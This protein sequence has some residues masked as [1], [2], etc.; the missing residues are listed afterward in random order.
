MRTG[1]PTVSLASVRRRLLTGSAWIFAAKVG[2]LGLGVVLSGLIAR[3]LDEPA[4]FGAYLMTN[5]LVIVGS[6]LAKLGLERALVR[7]VAGSIGTRE[8]GGARDAIRIALGWGAIGAAGV[9]LALWLG[10]GR[11]F[12]GDVLHTPLVASIIPIAAGWLF[13]VAMQSLCV[14][15]FRGLSRFGMASVLDH[16]VI[17]LVTTLVLGGIFVAGRTASLSTVVGL[18]AAVVAVVLVITGALLLRQVREL[19][20]P[21]RVTRSDMFRVARPLLVTNLG[22]YLLGSGVDLWVLGAFEPNR[23]VALYG[24]ASRLVVLV[25]TPLIIFSGVIPP[26]VAELHA[27]GRTAQLERALRAGA[28]LAGLPALGI[29]AIFLLFGPFVLATVYGELYRDAAPILAVLSIGRVLAVWAGSCGVALMMTGHQRAMM[30]ITLVSGS[31]SV[32]AGLLAAPRFGAIGVAV[33]TSSAQVLQNMLQLILVRRRLGIWTTIQF[34][35]R[36]LIGF[37]SG[38]AEAEAAGAAAAAL[39]PD[40]DQ[41]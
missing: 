14:E 11:W 39:V 24:S 33:T 40:D 27:Q 31:A 21:G 4:A 10:I 23:V 20:G 19:R 28:T 8:P 26:L 34:S 7:H 3:L 17:D 5:T 12:F 36:A 22:I 32:A 16:L 38:R 6:T 13:A 37:F 2:T 35:P 1:E 18:S 30:A 41:P 29:L 25:A 9:A 15:S